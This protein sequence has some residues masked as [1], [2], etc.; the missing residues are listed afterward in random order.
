MK[1]VANS[2]L[3]TRRRSGANDG[4]SPENRRDI[5]SPSIDEKNKSKLSENITGTAYEYFERRPHPFTFASG[6]QAIPVE[7]GR[8]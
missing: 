8:E 4:A 7:G 3:R 6:F 5:L 2:N 1:Y